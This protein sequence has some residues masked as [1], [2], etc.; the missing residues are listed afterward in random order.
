MRKV[1][2]GRIVGDLVEILD[3]LK[4]GELVV[5]NGQ[6]NLHD[7]EVKVLIIQ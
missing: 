6:I 5:T 3:G 7:N 1:V 2:P 4:E